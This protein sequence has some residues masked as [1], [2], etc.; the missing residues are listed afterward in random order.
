M[1]QLEE[2]V[3]L[4]LGIGFRLPWQVRHT[5]L[6]SLWLC[7]GLSFWKGAPLELCTLEKHEGHC[8]ICREHD[9]WQKSSCFPASF[10]SQNGSLL[11]LG[12]LLSSS[13]LVFTLLRVYGPTFPP[14]QEARVMAAEETAAIGWIGWTPPTLPSFTVCLLLTNHYRKCNSDCPAGVWPWSRSWAGQGV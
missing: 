3:G 6:L 1:T 4:D 13:P 5:S 7:R 11:V 14:P 8:P 9:R 10:T 12:G 2:G